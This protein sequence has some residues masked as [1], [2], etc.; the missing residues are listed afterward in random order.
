MALR[1]MILRPHE[2]IPEFRPFG[3]L[4]SP[5]T[6]RASVLIFALLSFIAL[7]AST[8]SAPISSSLY[9]LHTNKDRGVVFGL[10]GWCRDSDGLCSDLRMGYTRSPELSSSLTGGLVL[11]PISSVMVLAFMISYIPIWR[12]TDTPVQVN[13]SRGL[14]LISILTSTL[15]FAFMLPIFSNTASE[16]NDNGY[17]A[18]YGPLPALSL[19][20][21]FFLV[22]ATLLI[23]RKQSTMIKRSPSKDLELHLTPSKPRRARLSRMLSPRR[24][25]RL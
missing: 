20:S 22:L 10:W 16:F 3:W 21:I 23:F 13:L 25:Y 7:M 12:G 6:A 17:S 1:R 19:L 8:F 4:S 9:F 11:Y 14:G 18:E 24:L 2:V 5:L 15:A